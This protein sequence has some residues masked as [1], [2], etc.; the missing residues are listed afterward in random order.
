MKLPV[1]WLQDFVALDGISVEELAHK[2]TVSGLEVGEIRFVGWKKPVSAAGEKQAFKITGLEWDP[3]KFV[4]A[5]IRAVNPHPNA[6]R[7]VLCDLFDGQRE[8]VVLTGAPNLFPYKGKGPL[9]APIKVAYAREGAVLYDGHKDGWHLTRLK[10]TKIRGVVSDSMVCSEKELGISEAHEGIIILDADAPVGTPLA[11]YM[12]DAVLDIDILPNN[13]RNANVLGIAREVAAL[14]NR[15]LKKPDLTLQ[16]VGE[17]LLGQV[18]IEIV[19]PELNPRFMVGLIRNVKIGPSPYWVQRRLRL[20]GMRPVNNVVDATNYAMLEIGEPLHAFDYDVLQQRAGDDKVRI[21][22][23]AA[24][25][26]EEL[27]TLDGERRKLSPVNVLVCDAQGPLSIAGVMGGL[28]SEVTDQTRNVLLEAASWNFINI[29]RTAREHNLH[30]EASY[31]FSRGVHPALAEEGLRRGLYWM[32][33]W[34]D[35]QIAP[36]FVDQYPLPPRE[37][38]VPISTRDVQRLLGLSLGAD[39]IAALLERLAFSCRTEGETV[40]ATVPPFRMDIGEGV[41]GRADLA[42]E[43][44]RLYGYDRFP[45]TPIADVIPAPAENPLYQLEERLRDS[46]VKLGLQEIVTYR[47]TAP[48]REARLF[49]A[50]PQQA[51]AENDYVR[52]ANPIAPEKRVLRQHLLASVLDVLAR[53]RRQ[54]DSLALFEVGPVFWPQKGQPLPAEPHQLALALTGK[55]RQPAWDDGQPP[56]L[57]FFDLKGLLE[58]L[59]DD[60]MLRGA[61]FEP[62]PAHPFYHPGKSA[63]I[64]YQDQTLAQF[65]VLHPLVQ[66][67]YDL[68]AALAAELDLQAFLRVAPQEAVRPLSPFPPVIEDIALIV[69]ENVPAGQVEALIWQTGG[70]LLADV[71]LFDVYRGERLGEG[72]KSLAYRLTYQAPDRTLTDKDAAHLRKK[73]VKRLGREVGAQLRDN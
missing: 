66:E 49:A 43:I 34:S 26:G 57:D 50:D 4:V 70:K 63:R 6:D 51:P 54:A 48:E 13:A 5:E 23:R 68:P 59:L 60:L 72:K 10:K 18:E 38:T 44:A 9:P 1:S 42:E 67:A 30:S 47:L 14:F 22:T 56:E 35:G 58:A 69:D 36:D 29:R 62:L 33:R 21:I 40:Y 7:L 15:P 71:R 37:I 12:G 32:A 20:A 16:T 41:V 65:G 31:R 3:E 73:I 19:A 46:L 11:E 39:E 53:N 8:R 17:S 2:L 24:R 61:T 55:R 64:R 52:I 25:A 27:V 28:E 45:E